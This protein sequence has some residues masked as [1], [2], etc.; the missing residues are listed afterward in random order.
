MMD[1]MLAAFDAAG[2]CSTAAAAIGKPCD[3]DKA[4]A[5]FTKF[6]RDN[7]GEMGALASF[8]LGHADAKRRFEAQHKDKVDALANSVDGLF[9]ESCKDNKAM[10][11]VLKALE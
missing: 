11:D 2:D 3:C 1:K 10:Q 7:K 9:V 4:A 5:A 6:M 8:E